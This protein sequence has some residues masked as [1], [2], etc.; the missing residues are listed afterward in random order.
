MVIN[1]RESIRMASEKARESSR[2]GK[3][4]FMKEAGLTI[5]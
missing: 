5:E 1:T 3:G 2:Q 4:R